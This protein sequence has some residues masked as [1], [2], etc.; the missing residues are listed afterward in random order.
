MYVQRYRLLEYITKYIICLFVWK[1]S[2]GNRWF[3]NFLHRR[4]L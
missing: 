1:L 4:D 2:R 3:K